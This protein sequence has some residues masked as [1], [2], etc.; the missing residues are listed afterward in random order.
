M[1]N[2]LRE[3]PQTLGALRLSKF[4]EERI[5]ARGVKDELRDNLICKLQRRETLFPGIVGYDDTVIP[6]MVNAVL[7]RHNFILLGLRGQAKTRLIRMLTGLLD[8]ATPYV[9]GCE[10]HDNP[11]QP[12]CRRCR[13]L[14]AEQGD[15][16]HIAY[17]SADERYVEK[18][19]TPDVTIADMIGDIDPIKAARGGHDLSSEL[20]VHYGLLPRANRGIFAINE[21]PD[22]AGK[23][24]VGLFNIMQEGDVQIKGYPV[25]LPLDLMLAFTANPEDYTARGKI[26]TPL[27]DRIGS[28]IRTHYPVA[29]E[30]GIEI[31]RQEAWLER[32]SPI[33]S[34]LPSYIVEIVEQVA[35]LAREDKKVDKRSGVSQ[36][37]PISVME[38]IVSNAER[39]A[40]ATREPVAVPRVLDIYSALPSITGKIELEYEGELKGGDAV[41]RDLIRMAVGKV[42][43]KYYEGVN[44]SA[45]VQWFDLG[46]ALKLDETEDSASMVKQL[47]TIQGLLE[48]VRALGLGSNEPDALRV[49]A[50]EFIL[51]GLYAHRRISRSEERGFA[52][53]E[54]KRETIGKDDEGKRPGYRRPQFN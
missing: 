2:T 45:I 26:I 6:H 34:R 33:D 37:L 1:P 23:I 5:A 16:T 25:R 22:L 49:S 14:I 54:K 39:R 41:A 15:R 19:A 8:D 3:L 18:L 10:I 32:P 36:R 9:A 12:I 21:L 42:Y 28:E 53:E 13:D 52:A 7:S 46:G 27:K 24:Q 4:S 11:Y 35:F 17:L 51:E 50:A 48:K 30:Q 38:N 29:I 47:G 44:V 20:T 43:N 40:L 31:T